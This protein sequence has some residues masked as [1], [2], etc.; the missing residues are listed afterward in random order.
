MCFF[1]KPKEPKL[2]PL[3]DPPSKE[4]ENSAAVAEDERKK[5]RF[6]AGQA[7][8]KLSGSLGDPNFGSNISG[9][10]RATSLGGL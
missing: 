4:G 5:L 3:T 8:T 9:G 10:V 7:Q 1:K 6:R 2:P